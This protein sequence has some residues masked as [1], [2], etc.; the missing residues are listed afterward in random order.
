MS[1]SGVEEASAEKIGRGLHSNQAGLG[2]GFYGRWNICRPSNNASILG[3]TG[4]VA[5][6]LTKRL[7][8]VEGLSGRQP[9]RGAKA[10]TPESHSYR[11]FGQIRETQIAARSSQVKRR[12]PILIATAYGAE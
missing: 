3:E 7:S 5:F 2:I 4:F 6:G 11:G 10:M 8:C 12:F 1:A 9:T